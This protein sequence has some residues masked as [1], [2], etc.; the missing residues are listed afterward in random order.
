MKLYIGVTNDK[1]L[2]YI[3]WD[4]AYN[5]ERKT[6]S[7]CG[8]CYNEPKTEQDGEQEAFNT[9][10]NFDYWDE[11]Y[12]LKDIPSVLIGH[13]DYKEVAEEVINLDGWENTNGEYNHFGEYNNEEIYLNSSSGGQHQEERKNL[14]DLWISEDDFK[15]INLL[16]D[17]GH[18]KPLKEGSL[19]FMSSVFEKYK[20]FCSDEEALIKYLDVIEW[21]Q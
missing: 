19:K 5:E 13:I 14:K 18:L 11:I 1:E 6:F 21:Q 16:W 10:S 2:Y 4:K 20:K 17:S 3:E 9:L 7:L 15:K 8:G 12:N